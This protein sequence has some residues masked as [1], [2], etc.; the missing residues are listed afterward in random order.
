MVYQNWEKYENSGDIYTW[1]TQYTTDIK[2]R[3]LSIL[4]WWV[5]HSLGS[6]RIHDSLWNKSYI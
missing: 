2:G 5:K 3:P 6:D 1:N 4:K